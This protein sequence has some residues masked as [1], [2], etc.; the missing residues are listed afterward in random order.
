LLDYEQGL[1]NAAAMRKRFRIV[2]AILIV[3]MA[4]GVG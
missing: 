4:G 2:L 1:G 3:A